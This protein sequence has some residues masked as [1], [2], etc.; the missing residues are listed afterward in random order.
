MRIFD[1][2]IICFTMFC[3]LSGCGV[4]KECSVSDN[5]PNNC[6]NDVDPF[7]H[8]Q[9]TIVIP[10]GSGVL[11]LE[12]NREDIAKEIYA[13]A[14]SAG[15]VTFDSLDSLGLNP[16]EILD[17]IIHAFT[18]LPRCLCNG[19]MIQVENEF[20]F[21]IETGLAEHATSELGGEIPGGI[22]SPNYNI[23]GSDFIPS[24]SIIANLVKTPIVSRA[25]FPSSKQ[26][27]RESI[28]AIIDDGVFENN[29]Q[30][31]NRHLN[32]SFTGNS[33]HLNNQ[34]GINVLEW[35]DDV[36]NLNHGAIVSQV[37][38]FSLS[39]QVVYQDVWDKIKVLPIKAMDDCGVGTS[40][41]V[42][43]AMYCAKNEGA[44]VINMSIGSYVESSVIKLAVEE[45]TNKSRVIVASAGNK[46]Y[47]LSS[48][49]HFPSEYS[50]EQQYNGPFSKF[51]IEV[52]ST[53]DFY[54]NWNS[55]VTQ[56]LDISNY[57]DRMFVSGGIFEDLGKCSYKGTS[58]STPKVT[59][60]A[61][62]Q[63]ILGV[64]AIDQKANLQSNAVIINDDNN[65]YLKID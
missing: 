3:V 38:M 4:P 44:D 14:D 59:A 21:G 12:S 15:Q 62:H 2:A 32:H 57:R 51:V 60:K 28:V 43:C 31:I 29:F 46:K 47:D 22:W 8:G 6:T 53:C 55:N 18:L 23:D 16:D 45:V 35:P 13:Y 10:E 56:R 19:A 65:Q 58:V 26:K 25:R 64:V 41:N 40:F 30:N 5:C 9:M 17:S 54:N 42:A 63:S 39:H 52:G 20:L 11:S 24:P 49:E 61:L 50:D 36:D 34:F 48:R 1:I 27:I 37:M 7:V 33:S